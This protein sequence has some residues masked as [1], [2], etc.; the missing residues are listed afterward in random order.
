MHM[1]F[2][3]K[4]SRDETAI[5]FRNAGWQTRRSSIRNQVVSPDYIEGYTG[6]R[7]PNGFGG[8]SPQ[9]FAVLY[10]LDVF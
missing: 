3:N 8:S 6:Y 7:T 9:F 2:V 5:Q 10:R 1:L 4:Q